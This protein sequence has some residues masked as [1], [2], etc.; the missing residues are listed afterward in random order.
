MA[1]LLF[2]SHI[3][4]NGNELQNAVVQN[5]STAPASPTA[6]QFYFDTAL[7]T[8][9]VYDGENWVDALSQGDYSFTNGVQETS[10]REISI[11]LATGD[12]AGNVAFTAN[13]NGLAASVAPA[14]TSAAGVVEFA[15]DAEFTTGTSETLAVNPKQVTTAIAVATSGMVTETGAQTLTNKTI[16]A[17]DNTISDLTTGNF[18][19]GVVGTVLAGT[20]TA[21]N[22]VLP[23]EK[24]VADALATA[25]S[26]MVTETGA[27]TLT[28]KT[29]D[30]GNNT[31]SGLTVPN[32]STVAITNTVA[33]G[34]ESASEEKLVT[35]VGVQDAINSFGGR[36]TVAED[37]TDFL[38]IYYTNSTGYA[39]F[40]VYADTTVTANSTNLITSGAVATAIDNALV[41]GVIYKGTWAAA[42]QSDYSGITLPV[43]QGYM[44]YVSSG[45][46]VTIDGITWNAGDY[47][48]IN[49]DV[50]SGGTITSAKVQ[51]IDNTEASDIVR[52]NSVQTLTNKTI[53]AGSNTI[54]GL[55][56][57]NFASG[58][59][60]STLSGTATASATV[61]ASEKAVADALAGATSGMVTETGAQTL[62]NKTIDADSNSISNLETDNFKAGVMQTVVRATT[63][64]SD[65][66]IASELA[67]AKAV[68]ALP[69][70]FTATNG[71]LTAAGGVCTW[72]IANSLATTDV[73]VFIY[74]VSDGMQVMTETKVGASNIVVKFNSAAD[75]AASAYKAVVLG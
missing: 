4:L 53:A 67:V 63:S 71:A 50:A 61:F 5:L 69:H 66:A 2:Q 3:N 38:G 20:A 52:L 14:S 62:T 74:R 25:T 13:A 23:S 29:I 46:D 44:Y 73:D 27:Q 10:G 45:E 54:S 32:F 30:A 59:I 49:Q 19:A 39:T 18:K 16:D 1:E 42:N 6:G 56:A 11:K 34:E 24:A 64:A 33:I 47:L 40:S 15:T 41:G 60:A 75:I 51:K 9:R 21:A 72:T 12:N 55:T 36:L 57:S 58:A 37:S 70:K 68:A 8:L 48:L 17:D 28:N 7:D 65:T 22:T 35:E 43:K 31:I 26:G